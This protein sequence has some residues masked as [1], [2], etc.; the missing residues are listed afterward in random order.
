MNTV[1]IGILIIMFLS[2]LMGVMR[3]LTREVLGLISWTAA[4]FAA[5]FTM[6]LAQSL[7]RHY[8]PNPMLADIVGGGVLFIIFLILFS[9]ISQFFTGLVR[10]SK[11]GGIDR[12]LG[13]GY[14][15]LRGFVLICFVEIIM[16]VFVNRPEYPKPIQESHL[17]SAIYK[18]SDSVF[19]VLPSS[20]QNLIKQQQKKY[21]DQVAK[22]AADAISVATTPQDLLTEVINDQIQKG[23]QALIPGSVSRQSPPPS[24][25]ANQPETEKDTKANTQKTVEEL[26]RLKPKADANKNASTNYSK[27]QRRN[28]ERLLEQD[29]VQ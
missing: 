17:S 12:S 15:L 5:F 11:L 29:D 1:D 10:Q 24:A 14:G 20:L 21:G 26:A 28:M 8:I 6:P 22:P 27:Q 3:G 23:T 4:A 2:A 18:G 7:S 13:F 25:A 9:F 19:N 16:G